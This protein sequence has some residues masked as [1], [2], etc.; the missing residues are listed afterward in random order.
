MVKIAVMNNGNL[1]RDAAR[2]AF[3]RRLNLLL[4]YYDVPSKHEG[5]QVILSKKMDV[6]QEAARKWLEGESIPREDKLIRLCQL[7]ACRKSWL[8][9][10]EGEMITDPTLEEINRLAEKLKPDARVNILTLL[11]GLA[12]NKQP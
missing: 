8:Q 12:E 10:G 7:F 6:S 5:R 4:D 11:R 9:Q 2:S 1:Q 3:S